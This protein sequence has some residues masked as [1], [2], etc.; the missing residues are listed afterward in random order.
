MNTSACTARSRINQGCIG[1]G[2][3]QSTAQAKTKQFLSAAQHE[4]TDQRCECLEVERQQKSLRGTKSELTRQS[5]GSTPGAWT[6]DKI[7]NQRVKNHCWIQDLLTGPITEMKSTSD[8][9]QK[10]IHK[11][12]NNRTHQMQKNE[13][14]LKFNTIALNTRRSPPSSLI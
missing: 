7:V 3:N 10:R 14:S 6:K 11:R 1:T 9:S 8:R 12:K 13:F 2:Q 4:K 5:P